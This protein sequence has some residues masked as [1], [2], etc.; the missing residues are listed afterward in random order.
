MTRTISRR[1]LFAAGAT[2]LSLRALR[3]QERA[4]AA[5][6]R[7]KVVDIEEHRIQVPWADFQKYEMMHF[8]GPSRRVIYVVRTNSGLTGLGEAEDPVDKATLEKYIGTSPFDWVADETSK[9]LGT[10]MYDLMGKAAGIPVYKLIGPKYR[11]FV[12]CAAWHVSTHPK[13]MA[14]AVKHVASL[15][16]TWMKYHLSPFENVIDQMEAMQA[17][18][19]KGF[20]IHHDFTMGGSD[21]HVSELLQKIEKYPIAGAF[22]DPMPERDL[23]GYAELRAK[24]R[25]PILYHHSPL[26]SG[27][28]TQHRAADGYILGNSA[29]GSVMRHAG[30]FAM[31]DTPFSWQN[32]GGTITRAMTLHMQAACK[33]A[34]LHFNNDT[35]SWSADVTKERLEPVNG[36]VRVPEAPGLGVTLDRAELERLKKL[37]LPAQPK[38]IIK[39][40]FANG[41][42]MYNIG[43]T[44]SPIFMVRPDT[45]RLATLS[46]DAPVTT[47]YWD[48]DGTP[49]FRAMMDRLEK[50][51]MVLER[52]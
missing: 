19:P 20:K 4:D 27:F 7:L 14:A 37:Q 34:Y 49:A 2:A 3:A 39:T 30:L 10:A 40:R 43:D 36:L 8:Y 15:G 23:K 5:F 44:R 29:I 46:Y 9:A 52:A 24:C 41:S 6:P 16:Y 1:G 33:T 18:A 38:W 51:G 12:P 42:T 25:L 11:S 21:D 47:E 28:E 32:T 50:E 31:L 45:R 48:P 22:E 26:G 35:E 17:V 13:R